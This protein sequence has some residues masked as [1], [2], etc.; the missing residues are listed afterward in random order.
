MQW[1]SLWTELFVV[2]L[3]KLFKH[4]IILIQLNLIQQLMIFNLMSNVNEF[5]YQF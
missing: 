1:I 2:S 5:V 3:N 4:M